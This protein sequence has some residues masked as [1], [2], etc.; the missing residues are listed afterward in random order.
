MTVAD[1]GCKRTLNIAPNDF[2]V[3]KFVSCIQLRPRF[4]RTRCKGLLTRTVSVSMS[5]NVSLKFY[6]CAN[7]DGPFD[8]QNGFRTHSDHHH[9]RHNG[10]LTETL[11]DTETVRENRP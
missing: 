7:G 9:N 8:G 2:D 11:T 5:V 1:A 4:N 10:N 3:K 6:H